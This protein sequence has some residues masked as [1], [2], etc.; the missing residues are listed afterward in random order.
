MRRRTAD[1]LQG[2]FSD[3]ISPPM[4]NGSK[5]S[6]EPDQTAKRRSAKQRV[7][8]LSKLV[9]REEYKMSYDGSGM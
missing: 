7:G 9:F 1:F 8:G 6:G 5:F 4:T 2:E 3:V